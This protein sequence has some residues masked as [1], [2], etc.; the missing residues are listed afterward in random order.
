MKK[1][2]I[3][4]L[5][6]LGVALGT[7][8]A[9]VTD[10]YA[11]DVPTTDPS[12]WS[13]SNP[14][15]TWKLDNNGTLTISG[16]GDMSF[17]STRDEKTNSYIYSPFQGNSKVKKVV[18]KNGITSI[19][20]SAFENCKN[21]KSISIPNTV[22]SIGNRAFE[23]CTSLTGI[24]LPKSVTYIDFNA[25]RNCTSLKSIDL[26]EGITNI[27]G[28]LFYGCK[29]LKSVTIP[30]SVTYIEGRAFA[31]CTALKSVL[32]PNSVMDFEWDSFFY[33]PKLT[34]KCVPGSPAEEY[35]KSLNKK[36]KYAMNYAKV[37]GVKNKSYTGKKVTQSPKVKLGSKTLKKG[38]YY[39]LSYKNNI[40]KG[41]ATLTIKGKGKY[42][43][44]ISKKFKIA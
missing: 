11:A 31:H 7:A 40:K 24:K 32:I 37:T 13:D 35:C 17:S 1:Q 19:S 10:T 41:T 18:I 23:N 30:K 21:L 44:S 38:K 33:C 12:S 22:T 34:I 5:A 42:T 29:S 16:E 3:S 20:L 8:A 39:T 14:Y 28:S 15:S 36:Y 27:S 4:T 6:A 43:G 9:P 2:I 26:P 25:F